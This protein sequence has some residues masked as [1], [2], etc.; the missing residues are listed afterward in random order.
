[1]NREELLTK[2]KDP[3]KVLDYGHVILVDVM[4]DDFAIEDAARISYQRGTRKTSDTRGLLRYLLRHRHTTPFEC[5]S[6]KVGVKLPIFVERQWARHRTAK[7]NEL[8]GRYSELPE[9]VYLP[10][11]DQVC[12]QD[13]K[14]KQGRAEAFNEADADRCRME[15][16]EETKGAFALYRSFIAQGMAKETARI[17]LPFGTYTEKIWT[18]D[19][20]NLLHFSKLRLDA[21]A[22]YEI[23]VYAEAIAS[24]LKAW[25]PLTWEAFED[26]QLYAHTFSR[27]EMISLRSALQDIVGSAGKATVC[28]RFNTEGLSAREIDAFFEALGLAEDP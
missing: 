13:K 5:C 17:H 9:E 14:N 16:R 11:R 18:Q 28:A 26:F 24:I 10:D 21:H 1:M 25:V 19:L 8:S 23:R 22:Q 27:Q 15:M 2:Y 6:L 20:H 4:G 3:I 7:W 12:F